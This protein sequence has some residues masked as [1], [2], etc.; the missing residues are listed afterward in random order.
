MSSQETLENGEHEAQPGFLKRFVEKLPTGLFWKMNPASAKTV[1][2]IAVIVGGFS[3][4][5]SFVPCF[6]QYA[7]IFA[8]PALYLSM[9]AIKRAPISE[10]KTD[11]IASV[12]LVLSF[13]ALLIGF[14]WVALVENAREEL[15]RSE[16]EFERE[17][18]RAF[19]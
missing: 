18:N 13:L 14:Y 6:G 9:L 11:T 4:L 8:A 7:I 1:A 12:A 2:L 5:F 19:K 15:N 3:L 17:W 16:R 10:K